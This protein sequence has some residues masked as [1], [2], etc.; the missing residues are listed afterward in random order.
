MIQDLPR[1]F[2]AGGKYVE[3][4]RSTLSPEVIE[5]LDRVQRAYTSVVDQEA[6]VAERQEEI[7]AS[8]SAVIAA[9]KLCA[10]FGRYDFHRLWLE[11]VKN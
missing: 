9:E 5:H 10:P 6:I 3:P 8:L 4:D 7:T 11:T 1:I 2:D